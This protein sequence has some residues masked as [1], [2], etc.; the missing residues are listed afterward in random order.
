M[1]FEAVASAA[2]ADL[3]SRVPG[4]TPRRTALVAVSGGRD[5]VALL[6]FLKEAGWNR[7]VV[8]H[9]NHGLRG[10]I[11][12][13]DARFVRDLAR[14]LG[15]KFE[16]RKI[17]VGPWAAR[18][19]LSI[20]TA[21]REARRKFFRAVAAKHRCRFLFTA[22]HAGDQAETIL[23][24]LCRGTSLDGAKGMLPAA[25]S[26]PGVTV[27]RPLLDIARAEIDR[28]VAALRL[29]YREDASNTASRHTRNRVRHEVL[30]LM[31]E[32]F[33][34]DVSAL[35]LRFSKL[36]AR[37]DA[38]LQ[39]LARAFEIRHRPVRPDGSLRITAALR[40]LEPAILSRIVFRWLT[41]TCAVPAGALEVETALAMLR[42]GARLRANLPGGAHLRRSGL[43]LW[44]EQAVA[45]P[46]RRRRTSGLSRPP[47]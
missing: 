29:K 45:R 10:R 34:R 8:C 4:L 26:L 20:E 39:R 12:D 22:H 2:I 31:N 1:S 27:L 38:A 15:L 6:H 37:D 35:L 33:R 23:H 13:T 46:K 41:A 30:P 42:D 5:S 36:A 14:R 11:A 40:A 25:E 21:G 3:R 7:L 18:L 47:R 32:V 44:V 16:S 9:L 28:H 19:G 43:R 17:R 24:R